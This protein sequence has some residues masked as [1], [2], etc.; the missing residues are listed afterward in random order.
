MRTRF[1]WMVAI[2]ALVAI[3]FL[4]ACNTKYSPFSNG[5]VV[6]PTQGTTEYALATAVMETFSLDLANG[7][8]SQIN[9]LSGPPAPGLPGEVILDPAGAYAYVIVHQNAELV[10][11]V[12]GVTVFPIGAD[13][14]LGPGKTRVLNPS[15]RERQSASSPR[16]HDRDG[17]DPS[18]GE[19]ACRPERIGDGSAGKTFCSWPT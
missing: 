2:L 19:C 12:T 8:L 1:T 6:V 18:P 3:G 5:L 16:W 11:S 15:T 4:M 7:E 9:N 10:A 13:G 14:A 17:G